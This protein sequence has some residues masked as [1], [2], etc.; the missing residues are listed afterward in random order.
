M[1][2]SVVIVDDEPPARAKLRRLL[3]ELPDFRVVAEAAERAR[4][5]PPSAHRG[6]TS[7]IS[8]SSSVRTAAST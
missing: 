1:S 8:T 3:E 7:C 5:W 4:P 2:Y 6:P